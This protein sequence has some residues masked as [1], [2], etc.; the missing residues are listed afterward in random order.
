MP[1]RLPIYELESDLIRELRQRRRLLVVAPTGSGKSTQIP[2][3]LLRHGLLGDGQAVILQPRRLAAR[4]LAARVAQELGVSLGREVGYTIRF[5]NQSGPHTRIRF[6]TEGILLRQMLEQP[7]LSGITALIFD[8]FHERHL[9]GDITLARA[10][11]L[12]EQQRPDLLVLVM[13]ATLD[14]TLLR[15][16]LERWQQPPPAPWQ[17]GC[18]VLESEGGLF[19]VHVRHLD[20]S[21]GR[22][23]P[24]VWEKA[25]DVFADYVRQGG[26]G[27]VLVFMPGAY[28]I[29]QTLRALERRPESAGFALLPLH[30][31][32]PPSQQ[33]AALR[34]SAR[35][36]VVVATNV[37]ETSLTIPGIRLVIDSGLARIPR[38]DPVRGINTLWIERISRASADQRAG[39]AGR[40]GPGLCIRLWSTADHL[41]RPAQEEP[42]IRRLD[43]AE[44]VLLLKA[45]GVSDLSSFRW[46]EPPDA[47]ALARAED[48]L[49][50]LGAL[51]WVEAAPSPCG[52]GPSTSA[53]RAGHRITRITPLGRKMLAFPVHPR[54][55]RMLLA[56][57]D[58][59][60]VRE[61][62]LAA[63]LT[64]GRE[65]LLRGAPPAVAAARDDHLG[66]RFGS[67]FHRL[68]RA[69]E[70]VRQQGY[71]FE[72][73]ERLGV[74]RGAAL[75]VEEL[76]E[77]FLE[78]ARREGLEIRSTPAPD[79]ALARTLLTAFPDHLARR[80]DPGSRRCELTGGRRGVLDPESVVQ[81][82]A[83]V[84]AAEVREVQNS[85][86]STETV[87][88]LLAPID[89]GWIEQA[90]PGDLQTVSRVW[91]D[92]STRRVCAETQTRFRSVLVAQRR[93]E[94][95]PPEEAAR[96]LAEELLAGRLPL[97][98]WDHAVEQWI[99]RL[100]FL[101]RTCPELGLPPFTEEARRS[102]LETLCHGAFSYKEIKERD[103]A[104]LVRSWLSPQQQALLEEH[105]PER[106]RLSNG[107]T[108]RVLYSNDGPP[109]I[110]LRIQELY[111]VQEAPRVALGRVPL[112]VQILSPG[113][114]P[115]QV[116]QDLNNFWREHYPRL[117]QEL[118]RRYPKHEW[119]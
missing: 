81:T 73:C 22:N 114:K 80:L 97:K 21:P 3:M 35:R 92:P 29:Q 57:Q 74:H 62:C 24:P 119:R 53:S 12:Q 105:A 82:S 58:H 31:Q 107:R 1:E 7:E 102:V 11:D 37:A 51:E 49:V 55:A 78:I 43:L 18:A 48:L 79:S 116:T 88:S 27:D 47:A 52:A 28:E 54:Y 45:T 10:L 6:V 25:A 110:S 91:F 38:Y 59:G 87:L 83:W 101:A 93:I 117:R 69:W 42:E 95:P 17:P 112:V 23:E 67:D 36:K 15:P 33:D 103:V 72:L 66:T 16:Y 71:P 77:Q 61:A 40:T 60:C 8:E 2:Q 113:M 86:G 34:P 63:A 30:G 98:S 14:V 50:E 19:P 75:Q 89:P 84:V 39:R 115:V 41:R 68:M 118:Q 9:Y 76:Y 109:R 70:Y 4:L 20:G 99:T 13:S 90:F 94:P 32:L 64:Q 56:A 104:P 85:H 108:P 96:L 100:N 106:V 65:L 5:D 46:L 26:E 44:V 111:G